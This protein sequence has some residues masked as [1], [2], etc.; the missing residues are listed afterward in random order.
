[1]L[2]IYNKSM[3]RYIHTLT[4]AL[5][6]IIVALFASNRANSQCG[7]VTLQVA[8]D[9]IG[10][11]NV[12]YTYFV[13]K[14]SS[15]L[16]YK[17]KI[18]VGGYP[19]GMVFKYYV[20]NATGITSSADTFSTVLTSS[21]Y[22]NVK[23]E[24]I[25]NLGAIV[26]TINRDSIVRAGVG[27]QPKISFVP[28]I[29]CSG[30]DSVS[31]IDSTP[32]IVSRIWIIDGVTYNN[33]SPIIRHKFNSTGPKKVEVL[34]TSQGD[35]C[36]LYKKYD[37][38]VFVYNAS[39]VDF[40]ASP[41]SG[42]KAFKTKF[43]PSINLNGNT[44]T[45]YNWTFNGGS[46]STDTTSAP[47]TISYVNAGAFDASLKITT[48][49]GC[50]YDL[51]KTNYINVG[52]TFILN[53]AID[54]S[55]LCNRQYAKFTN[56]TSGLPASGT[57]SWACLGS[58][59]AYS[60]GNDSFRVN[61]S[62]IGNYKMVAKFSYNGCSS[63]REIPF[64]MVGPVTQFSAKNKSNCS[65][66]TLF[67]ANND[68]KTTP[69]TNNF[70]RWIV[71]DSTGVISATSQ[72]LNM[73]TLSIMLTKFGQYTVRLIDSSST[74]GCIDSVTYASFFNLKRP[75][76]AFVF[77]DSLNTNNASKRFCT[78]EKVIWKNNSGNYSSDSIRIWITLYNKL[79]TTMV[80]KHDTINATKAQFSFDT[81][82]YRYC[83]TG[84]YLGRM[85][86]WTDGGCLDTTFDTITIAPPKANF[87]MDNKSICVNSSVTFTEATTPK[88]GTLVHKFYYKHHDSTTWD[89]NNYFIG[90]S[91]SF[92]FTVPG[93]YSIAY[94]A[95]SSS[96]AL[97]KDSLVKVDS[98]CVNSMDFGFKSASASG[99]KGSTI[100]FDSMSVKNIHPATAVKAMKYEWVVSPTTGVTIANYKAAST[101]ITFGV[102]G[103]YDISLTI[104]DTLTGCSQTVTK[105]SMISIGL[106][107]G[108]SIPTT[109]CYKTKVQVT[110]TSQNFPN[111]Y[112]WS[113]VPST[114][115][116]KVIFDSTSAGFSASSPGISFPDSGC[117]LVTMKAW[118]GSCWDTISQYI[119]IE[120]V[121]PKFSVVKLADTLNQCAPK[122]V[123]FVSS[124]K[125]ASYHI[126]NFG[127]GN[128]KNV[129]TD[130]TDNLYRTNDSCFDVSLIAI[131]ANGCQDTLT[132]NCYIQFVGPVPKYKVN[133]T[134]GCEPLLV[135]FTDQSYNIVSK[136]FDY[137][138]G[139]TNNTNLSNH[140]YYSSTPGSTYDVYVTK[141][142]AYS[143]VCPNPAIYPDPSAGHVVDTIKVFKKSVAYFY[144]DTLDACEPWCVQF[145]DTSKYAQ[146]WYWDF[147]DGT[148]DTVRNPQHCYAPGT[149]NVKLKVNNQAG[150]GDSMYKASYIKVRARSKAAFAVNDSVKCASITS[151]FTDKSTNASIYNWDFGD[152]TTSTTKNPSHTFSP[153]KYTIKLVTSNAY[154]CKDSISKDTLI[155]VFE[156]SVPK[157]YCNI[158]SGCEPFSTQVFGDSS[159]YADSFYW[160][161]TKG[162]T[163]VSMSNQMNPNFSLTPGTY[164][165]RLY[166]NNINGC[167]DS[168]LKANYITV[169]NRAK[170]S[171]TSNDTLGCDTIFSAFTNTSSFATKYR[172]E[173]G[174]A[175]FDTIN[176]NTSHGYGVGSYNVMLWANN[177]NNC[178][179]SITKNAKVLV[180]NK[181]K[182]KIY[183]FYTKGCEPFETDLYGDSTLYAN[184]YYWILGNTNIQ[185]VKNPKESYPPGKYTVKLIASNSYGCLDSINM[186][187]YIT[188]F[189]KPTADFMADNQ[190]LCFKQP[191]NFTDLSLSDVAI[192]DWDWD[193]GDFT[194]DISSA[195]APHIYQIPGSKTV[196][197]KINNSN[198]CKDTLVLSNYIYM[199]DSIPPAATQIQYVS[200][201]N[202][203]ID[204]FW[205]QNLDT[206]FFQNKLYRD[207]PNNTTPPGINVFSSNIATDIYYQE[208]PPAVDPTTT[209]YAYSLTTA[210]SC[211]WVSLPGTEHRNM[212]LTA[213]SLAP[214]TNIVTWT[215]Y[216]G[217]GNQLKEY[218]IWKGALGT[219]QP[220]PV[221][222]LYRTVSPNDTS[223]IDSLLCDSD[224]HY[225]IYA[226]HKSQ[227]WQSLS[228]PAMNHAP[229][230]S[231]D[232]L[233]TVI[234]TTVI[235]DKY[236][237]TNWLP[238]NHPAIKRYIIDKYDD[239]KGWQNYYAFTKS[240]V[241][242]FI[243]VN[244]VDVH[245]RDYTYRVNVEDYC[246]NV[247]P[248]SSEIGRSILF[249]ASIDND[250]V[251]LK[252]K[253]YQYWN[254]GVRDYLIQILYPGNDWRKVAVVPSTDT[255]Y[256]DNNVYEDLYTNYCYRVVAIEN[257]VLPD[258]SISNIDCAVV[259]SR[260]FIPN[261]FSP[262]GKGPGQNEVFKPTS[263]SLYSKFE[264]DDINDY[265]FRVYNRWGEVVFETHDA[266][267][268]WDGTFKGKP[269]PADVYAFTVR[270]RGRDGFPY[271]MNGNLQ[272]M[273]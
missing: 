181:P 114:A 10:A 22:Y 190:W 94:V 62:N 89:P 237:L 267:K 17:L 20:G 118:K 68:T 228:N 2:K 29:L 148:T 37:T 195:P 170:P 61:F 221:F 8:K 168:S 55:T 222:D 6:I 140:T 206:T 104:T 77:R 26:C 256:T 138:D 106:T 165:V 12:K 49:V 42:C 241:T 56:V 139:S 7:S 263:L 70:F 96:S 188:V 86:S 78:C 134:I 211:G 137:G 110:N 172:W 127:D 11:G 71:S 144:S 179:D 124:S 76:L 95:K 208:T 163:I 83:D 84:R 45:K 242:S 48:S 266:S 97:C 252:W 15:C 64:R 186:P 234:R 9:S 240:N 218:Q 264:G 108:F 133:K 120:R 232:T 158:T 261:A 260:I 40:N 152:A 143:N 156:K 229:F 203:N 214:M 128:T 166:T 112:T 75:K 41:T 201:N 224:Y 130:S 193:F 34:L 185:N 160:V 35:S 177:I 47:D 46:P 257:D 25:N 111:N 101:N 59:N 196:T 243:D 251:V 187:N 176:T 213:A 27:Q 265:V 63:T 246:G 44:V 24:L 132:K 102:N 90:S 174:D 273:R 32:G 116:K 151:N 115:S 28:N 43:S 153:G 50:T 13:D 113:A 121:I 91:G 192:T 259:P 36:Q 60:Y 16:P 182:P 233:V 223:M 248:L 52:D 210:D 53:I 3:K 194:N 238:S 109:A 81:T 226:I 54:D 154:G 103:V 253:P 122:F 69:G 198:G 247:S 171:F 80:L 212:V 74:F 268:G 270:A 147:G 18:K 100:K 93:C 215:P 178:A 244:D 184:S 79:D 65:S 92:T 129:F 254:Y 162:A 236:V 191:V 145:H 258:T 164:S 183:S 159:L 200:Y 38:A 1:M 125:N 202:G 175:T 189:R 216:V 225:Q 262:D 209:V 117:Y 155:R 66:P 33:N 88:I 72:K 235:D 141:L 271:D 255:S 19:G 173:F 31:I 107:A 142:T 220:N 169:F 21:G 245:I 5:V 167:I 67:K 272:L 146:T 219:G 87:L 123:K 207:D 197:L 57:M 230:I 227:T 135:S 157:I 131:N 161:V 250:Y 136:V 204:I 23:V 85:I 30:P 239:T 99:C 150:C 199:D 126:W 82:Q 14:D 98:V 58:L 51:T 249:D 119:C 205:E 269:S 39:T 4:K 180:V 149:Y 217:W 73:D 231:P 105:T